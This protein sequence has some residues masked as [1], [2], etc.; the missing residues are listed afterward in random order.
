MRLRGVDLKK[1]L[2]LWQISGFIFTVIAGTLLHFLYDWSNQSIIVSPFS[3]VNE[4]VW[5]HMKLLFFPMFL[6]ALIEY[7]V[8]GKEN[9]NFW[10]AKLA[11]TAT[12][13]LL[14]P[15]LYYTVIGAFG[16]SPDWFN[17]AIFFLAAGAAYFSETRLLNGNN[18]F[19]KSPPIAFAVLC[20]IAAAFAVLTFAPPKIPLFRDPITG[21]YGI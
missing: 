19:C 1:S 18:S 2:I 20:I 21:S 6:F 4:S 5:E 17:I 7:R 15:T 9:E 3:A 11:G 12:G 16:V 13:L 8:I 10:C 14:I